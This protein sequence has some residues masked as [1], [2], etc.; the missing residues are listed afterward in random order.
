MI[1]I[2]DNKIY[3]FRV[4]KAQYVYGKHIELEKQYWCMKYQDRFAI[5]TGRNISECRFPVPKKDE[6]FTFDTEEQLFA[7]LDSIAVDNLDHIMQGLTPANWIKPCEMTIP[8]NHKLDFS[9][10]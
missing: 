10:K 2:E 5:D 6:Q 4:G 1:M 8:P 3:F 9:E 7:F